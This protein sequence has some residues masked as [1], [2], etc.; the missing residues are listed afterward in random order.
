MAIT[1]V[2]LSLRCFGF[3][4]F[5]FVVVV[6]HFKTL[7]WICYNI[8]SVWCFDFD[9]WDL[10][11]PT[12]DQTHTLCIGRWSLNQWTAREVPSVSSFVDLSPAPSK[13]LRT[14]VTLLLLVTLY[15]PLWSHFFFH[16]HHPSLGQVFL[17]S[18]RV[19]AA[20]HLYLRSFP[21]GFFTAVSVHSLRPKCELLRGYKHQYIPEVPHKRSF[22][23]F[24]PPYPTSPQGWDC[25]EDPEVPKWV[26]LSHWFSC[27]HKA[28]SSP[29]RFPSPT[30]P[31]DACLHLI[32]RH[33]SWEA[34][35]DAIR[36]Y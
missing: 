17:I 33:L 1:S 34:L 28:A 31:W 23:L 14:L 11:S 27:L 20:A 5:S 7:Y 22:L 6:D 24:L 18:P 29:T 19:I 2:S 15:K 9:V 36:K 12:R 8:A 16:S 25:S 21:F 3:L 4:R 35:L 13:A 26:R 30:L 32:K 10:S